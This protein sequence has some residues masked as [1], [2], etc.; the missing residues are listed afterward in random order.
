[1]KCKEFVNFILIII[2]GSF[3]DFVI[4]VKF[5]WVRGLRGVFVI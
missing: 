3:C 4:G 5:F 1:M 2:L